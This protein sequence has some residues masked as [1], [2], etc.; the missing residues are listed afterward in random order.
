MYLKNTPAIKYLR[1][2]IDKLWSKFHTLI[3]TSMLQE[4]K[5]NIDSICDT[6]PALINI[7]ESFLAINR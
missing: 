3:K 6:K 7:Y 4:Q 5:K 1:R 2:F